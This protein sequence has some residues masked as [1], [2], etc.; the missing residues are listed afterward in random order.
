MNGNHKK[1]RG[2]SLAEAML[3]TL[4][5]GIATAGLLL[6]FSTGA[7]IQAEGNKRTLAAKLGSDLM[8][9]V[10]STPFNS[11]VGTYNGYAEVKGEV[12][13]T[14][15]A[16]LLSKVDTIYDN[17]NRTVNCGYVYMPQQTGSE[18]PIFIRATVKVY[19]DS[20]EIVSLSRLIGDCNEDSAFESYSVQ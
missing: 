13:G 11:I 5:L 3:A 10:I 15:K 8:E 12:M 17:F 1:N 9:E 20:S 7:S 19:Y 6:P 18:P 14:R 4:L 16:E 2:L